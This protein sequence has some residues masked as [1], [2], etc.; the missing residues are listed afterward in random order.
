MLWDEDVL[1][2]VRRGGTA[3]KR[4]RSG[5][6]LSA[7]RELAAFVSVPGMKG[8]KSGMADGRTDWLA[9]SSLSRLPGLGG[10]RRSRAKFRTCAFACVLHVLRWIVRVLSGEGMVW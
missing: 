4:P 2:V 8:K 1:L 9:G 7:P 5:E 3:R 6:V 10:Y